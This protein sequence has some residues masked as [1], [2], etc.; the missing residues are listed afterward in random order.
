M[1][2][3]ICV[4]TSVCM[5]SRRYPGT[6]FE[7]ER[8]LWKR[9]QETLYISQWRLCPLQ[10]YDS[11]EEIWFIGNSLNQVISNC[12]T[13]F[14]LL[15]RK[16]LWAS[17]AVMFHAKI[18]RQSLGHSSLGTP[19]SA[20]ASLTERGQSLIFAD[21]SPYTFHTLRCSAGC[22]PSRTQITF[23]RFST[24]FEG[25]VPHF[26][27]CCTHCIVP[28]SLLNHLNSFH[29]RMF[30]LNAKYDT[31]SLL[32]SVI[33]NVTVTQCT[34]SPKGIYRP[35]WLAQWSGHCLP[36]GIPAHSPWPP[37]YIDVAQTVPIILTTAGLSPGGPRIHEYVCMCVLLLSLQ[38]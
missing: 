6:Y 33:S 8:H 14:L 2:V 37:L 9:I 26:Y 38:R 21:C 7:K 4:Y 28:E 15:W 17:L 25:F 12:S 13:M 30:K 29:G 5:R 10:R 24:I 34:C 1:R 32:Y 20:S 22:R 36:M 35:P 19:R 18:L 3:Y 16:K 23:N 31:D 11:L 27:L